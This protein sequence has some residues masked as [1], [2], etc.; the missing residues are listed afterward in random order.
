MVLYRDHRKLAMFDA[1]D[2]SVVEVHVCEP[3]PRCTGDVVPIPAPDCEAMILRRNLDSPAIEVLHRMVS[4]VV[5]ER[6][7]ERAASE[8]SGNELMA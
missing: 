5:T 8:G 4:A 1:L 7:L 6:K 3:Q 2:G